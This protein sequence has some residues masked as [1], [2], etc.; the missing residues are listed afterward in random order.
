M[1]SHVTLG[2]SDS[3]RSRE[4]YD[5]VL[6]AL[7]IKCAYSGEGDAAYRSGDD[8][9]TLWILSP[10]NRDPATAGNGSHVALLAPN[11]RAV[12]ELHQL[13]LAHGGT[14]EGAPGPRLH[15]HEHYNGAYVRDPDGNKL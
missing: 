14:D 13:A 3:S 11:H 6:D 8:P 15:Y 12:D 9:T 4:F 10:F 5:H 2:I 7:D 1:F